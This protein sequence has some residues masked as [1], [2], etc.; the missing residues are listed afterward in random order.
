VNRCKRLAEL[1]PY[2]LAG[3]VIIFCKN[4]GGGGCPALELDLN[5]ELFHGGDFANIQVGLGN[6][7]SKAFVNLP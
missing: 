7:V 5:F 1:H 2:E 4:N 3:L 6:F